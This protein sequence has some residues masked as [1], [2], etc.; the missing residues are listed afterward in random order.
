MTQ[1]YHCQ[2]VV[3]LDVHAIGQRIASLRG[4]REGLSRVELARRANVSYTF[5]QQLENATPKENGQAKVPGTQKLARIAEILGVT[6][7]ELLYGDEHRH[8]T[9]DRDSR[10][11]I[12][13]PARREVEQIL[14]SLSEEEIERA[15]DLL[16]MLQQ[17]ISNH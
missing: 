16:R 17:A 3:F 12:W 11:Q 14:D 5:L 13:S 6:V 4:A 2:E 1:K 15:R 9:S 7:D 10:Q 8:G